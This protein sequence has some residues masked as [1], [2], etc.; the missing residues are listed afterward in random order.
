MD[1]EVLPSVTDLLDAMKDDAPVLHEQL[2]NVTNANIRPGG[3]RDEGDGT[4]STN[5]ANHFF[6]EQGD[7]EQGFKEADVIVEREFRTSSVHQGYIEPHSA[8]AD[9]GPDGYWR[10]LLRLRCHSQVGF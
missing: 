7:I 10:S 2:A 1:Y 4:K 5:I 3:L 6:F 8:T 9:W